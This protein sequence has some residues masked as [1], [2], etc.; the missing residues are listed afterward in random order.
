MNLA[1]QLAA[2]RLSGPQG[3]AYAGEVVVWL[4]QRAILAYK[5]ERGTD[6]FLM[7]VLSADGCPRCEAEAELTGETGGAR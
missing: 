2:M 3:R 1:A 4:T 7:R 6:R 5:T